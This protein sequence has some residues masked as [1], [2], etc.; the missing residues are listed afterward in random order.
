VE[1]QLTSIVKDLPPLFERFYADE[2][3]RRCKVCGSL[4]PG[5]AA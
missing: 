4:H 3:L 1:V 5:R 2:A